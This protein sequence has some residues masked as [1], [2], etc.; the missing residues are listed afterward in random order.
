MTFSGFALFHFPFE[1]VM[2][3]NDGSKPWG[4][5]KQLNCNLDAT[6]LPPEAREQR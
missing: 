2:L 3:K 5:G 6:F 4:K 1:V